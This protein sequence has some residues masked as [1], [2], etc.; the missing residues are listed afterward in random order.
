VT[1][2][3]RHKVRHF[4]KGNYI[5]PKNIQTNRCKKCKRSIRVDNK[6]RLCNYCYN[7]EISKESYKRRKMKK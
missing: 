6:S 7:K 1:N 5:I 3:V 4:G 2:K